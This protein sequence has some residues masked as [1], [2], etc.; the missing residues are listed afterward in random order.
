MRNDTQVLC[1]NF[2]KPTKLEQSVVA[3]QDRRGTKLP[4]PSDDI[5][6]CYKAKESYDRHNGK[7]AVVMPQ[8][9]RELG[10]IWEHPMATNPV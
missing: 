7:S 1:C 9:M 6:L 10:G 3:A 2:N 5:W 4:A 8:S